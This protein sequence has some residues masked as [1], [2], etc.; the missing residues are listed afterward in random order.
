MTL[1]A[2][3]SMAEQSLDIPAAAQ[4]TKNHHVITLD[5]VNNNVLADWEAAQAGAQI[6][7]AGPTEILVTG[8][9]KKP[10]GD[11]IYQ[12]VGDVCATAFGSDI[13][14][15]LVEIEVDF[16]RTAV[17]HQLGVGCSLASR[18][19]PRCFI[20][21]ASPRMDSCVMIRPSPLAR[22]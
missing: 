16:W 12:T 10:V 6:L 5:P 4:H 11:G 9:K 18:A 1:L 2:R 22:E 19:R 3:E 13:I 14:P 7:I 15:D 17:C 8:Q 20:S 21:S